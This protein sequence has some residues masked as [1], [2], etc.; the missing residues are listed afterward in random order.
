MT[1]RTAMHSAC[2]HSVGHLVLPGTNLQWRAE[3]KP[4]R[5]PTIAEECS[6]VGL[7]HSISLSCFTENKKACGW[8]QWDLLWQKFGIYEKHVAILH[9]ARSEFFKNLTK[10]FYPPTSFKEKHSFVLLE[11]AGLV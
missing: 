9:T 3:M 11:H 2:F 6:S 10:E 1:T 8:N 5:W 7:A 4:T